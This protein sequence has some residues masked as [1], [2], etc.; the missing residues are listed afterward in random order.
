[1][2]SIRPILLAAIVLLCGCKKLFPDYK[3]RTSYFRN[4]V[5]GSAPDSLLTC[6]TYNIQLGFR[7]GQDPWDAA[8]SGGSAA[9][10]DSI[11][12]V[13]SRVK[14][15]II[16][17]QEVPRNRSNSATQ[18]FTEQL[19]AR[20]HMNYAFG[21]H[22][23]NEPR[24]VQPP[25]GEWGNAILTRFTINS[26][27]NHENE[28]VSK[29]RRRSILAAEILVG[30]RPVRVYSLH[31]DPLPTAAATAATYFQ[32]RQ[33]EAQLILGDFNMFEVP[34]LPSTNYADV[35]NTFSPPFISIDRIYFS[36]GRFKPR[37]VDF[38]P[39]SVGVSDHPAVYCRLAWQ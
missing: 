7:D 39:H 8:Q 3:T 16:C 33:N 21:A 28:Y 24:G 11:A 31:F 13:L 38:I 37:S 25:K 22:A 35:L 9:Q 17:L 30:S 14:P 4:P 23:H 29:W 10:L 19:A 20:L 1:M 26:I 27:E 12:R 32:E 15:D 5:A 18:D 6:V 2:I 34:E 36:V